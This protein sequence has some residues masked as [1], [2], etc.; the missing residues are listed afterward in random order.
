MSQLFISHKT[1]DDAFASW[2]SDR[3]RRAGYAPWVDH[4]DIRAGESWD[5][6]VQAA[7]DA[8]QALVL[9]LTPLAVASDN[10]Q[11]EWS[12]FFDEKKPIV[13]VLLEKCKLPYRLRRVQW[14]NF[15][16]ESKRDQAVEKLIAALEKIGL[17]PQT[18]APGRKSK[19]SPQVKAILDLDD[20]PRDICRWWD[21]YRA[22]HPRITTKPADGLVQLYL[23]GIAAGLNERERYQLRR[24]LFLR[25]CDDLDEPLNSREEEALRNYFYNQCRRWRK[26]YHEDHGQTEEETSNSVFDA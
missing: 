12:Y 2:L 6:S 8:A 20:P 25:Y 22:A 24:Y 9:V 23:A 16:D 3:L 15:T 4:E 10:V 17:K 7:L 13:P 1:E 19:I 11:D 21:A 18:P 14:V 5:E 26:R